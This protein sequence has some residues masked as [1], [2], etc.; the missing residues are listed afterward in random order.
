MPARAPVVAD[1]VRAT[2]SVE[3]QREPHRRDGERQVLSA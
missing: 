1:D 2:E 3:G